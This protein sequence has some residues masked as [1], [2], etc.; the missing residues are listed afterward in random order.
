MPWLSIVIPTYNRC[1]LLERTLERLSHEVLRLDPADVEVVV[2]DNAS[3]DATAD[4]CR[5]FARKCP[6]HVRIVRQPQPLPPSEHHV[7]AMEL[8]KGAFVKLCNDTL[9]VRPGALEMMVREVRRSEGTDTLL[10]F[11]ND[12]EGVE[13]GRCR[14]LPDLLRK[15]SYFSTWIMPFGVW[16][17]DLPRVREVFAKDSTLL[18]QTI[19]LLGEM[20]KGRTLDVVRGPWCEIQD[21]PKKGGYNVAEVFGRNY[22]R[23]L[24]PYVRNG[25]LTADD[26]AREKR[27]ILRH[28]NY[29]YFDWRRRYAFQRTGYF[30]YM[31]P[32][33]GRY[34]YF[35][36]TLAFRLSLRCVGGA[37]QALARMAHAMK[38]VRR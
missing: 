7:A 20:A 3:S 13:P 25:L 34:P 24:E 27:R 29:Q 37:L 8:S 28:I 14:N 18:P 30:R 1:S 22:F 2:S 11:A 9:L 12:I 6:Q 26:L 35:Y 36:R 31:M 33:Y 5:A 16:R 21:V 23:I 38:G 32:L 17:K 15:V 4:V 10:W 19:F